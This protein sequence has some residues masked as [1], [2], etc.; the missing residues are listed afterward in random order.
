MMNCE[1]SSRRIL[2]AIRKELVIALVK[3]G[4]KQNEVAKMLHV[5][6][7]AVTQY[8]KGKRGKIKLNGAE[9]SEAMKIASHGLKKGSIVE[10]DICHLCEKMQ[11][12][13]LKLA[14]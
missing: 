10:K 12:R 6:P 9:K 7:A 8:L 13:I 2:P 4:K 3:M 5:T 1:V 14:K 11:S